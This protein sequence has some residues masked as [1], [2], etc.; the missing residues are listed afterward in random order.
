MLARGK[1]SLW[2]YRFSFGVDQVWLFDRKYLLIS[3][4]LL[5]FVLSVVFSSI[6]D[7]G[8]KAAGNWLI[9]SVSLHMYL[10]AASIVF[11][12]PNVFTPPGAIVPLSSLSARLSI[13]PAI[14]GCAL[15]TS[16]RLRLWQTV[17]FGLAS[18]AFFLR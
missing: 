4:A 7:A 10:I 11:L 13:L 8:F 15:L 3:S 2:Q 16:A 5:L 12:V 18:I 6:V 14:F 17:G 1:W 9:C